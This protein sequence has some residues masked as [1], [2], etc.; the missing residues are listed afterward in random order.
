MHRENTLESSRK[1]KYGLPRVNVLDQSIAA[2]IS[3]FLFWIMM[4]RSF[5]FSEKI[6]IRHVQHCQVGA[7]RRELFLSMYD[8][9]SNVVLSMLK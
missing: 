2:M 7:C 6:Q 9:C 5:L 3:A 4:H 8:N 1:I